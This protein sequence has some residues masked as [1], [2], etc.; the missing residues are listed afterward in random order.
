MPL[1]IVFL[2]P[3][4]SRRHDVLAL[5]S[6]QKAIEKT[7]RDEE[8]AEQESDR[9]DAYWQWLIVLASQEEQHNEDNIRGEVNPVG[10]R[11][12]TK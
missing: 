8:E 10:H 9:V 2:A 11:D 12:R 7:T 6:Q 1:P 3:L 4:R 5:P